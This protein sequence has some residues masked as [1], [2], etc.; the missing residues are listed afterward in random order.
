MGF[1]SLAPSA[2][3]ECE[4]GCVQR[5]RTSASGQKTDDKTLDPFF[6][7]SGR[8]AGRWAVVV[9]HK[10]CCRY[11]FPLLKVPAGQCD[12]VEHH[13]DSK[14]WWGVWNKDRPPMGHASSPS[15]YLP[16]ITQ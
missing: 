3:L 16:L 12:L 13:P 9:S 4:H 8:L 6:V 1:K 10:F 15:A 14:N 2:T 11:A 7:K 5:I